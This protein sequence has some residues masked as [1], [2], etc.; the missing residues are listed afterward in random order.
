M[1]EFLWKFG[2][3]IVTGAITLAGI[4]I[5]GRV[6]DRIKV[7]EKSVDEVKKE[8]ESINTRLAGMELNIVRALGELKDSLDKKYVQKEFCGFAHKGE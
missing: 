1:E 6:N 5:M 4:N 8:H 7:L 3:W 2:Y